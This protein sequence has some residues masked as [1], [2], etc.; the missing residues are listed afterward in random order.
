[1]V[2]AA[3]RRGVRSNCL[4]GT[5]FPFGV[6]KMFWNYMEVMVVPQCEYTNATELL[7]SD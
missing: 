7:L 2:L 4:M 6:K 1:M 5:S 3:G